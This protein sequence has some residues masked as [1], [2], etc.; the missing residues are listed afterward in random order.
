MGRCR[1][2]VRIFLQIFV[3]S[4][5][6][7]QRPTDSGNIFMVRPILPPAPETTNATL[8]PPRLPCPPFGESLRATTPGSAPAIGSRGCAEW[9]AGDCDAQPS[10]RKSAT[11][12]DC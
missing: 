10:H 2:R 4:P 7:E 12:W 1:C 9:R 6:V 11:D 8:H 5:H 3:I